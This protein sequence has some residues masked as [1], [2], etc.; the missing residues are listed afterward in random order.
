[1][2][3]IR[4]FVILLVLGSLCLIAGLFSQS[5]SV[6]QEAVRPQKPLQYEAR[7]TIKLIQVIVVDKQGKPVTNLRKEDFVLTDNGQEMKLT[8]YERHMLSL[9]SAEAPV[10]ERVVSTPLQ[11][12]RLLNRK[13]FLFFD[14]AYNNPAGVR[15]MGETARRFLDTQVLPTDEIGVVSY[16]L[17]NRLK[18]HLYL[19]TDHQKVRNLVSKIGLRDSAER[20]EDL[21]DKYQRQLK[22]GGLADARP[23]A[24][25][26]LPMPDMPGLDMAEMWRLSTITYI[27]SLTALAYAL[28][29]VPG[30]K[31]LVLFSEGIP[32]PVLYCFP[33]AVSDLGRKYENF[34]KELGTSNVSVHALYTGGITLGDSQ[35]GAWTLAKTSYETGG[36]YWGNMYNYEPFIEKVQTSTGSYYVLGYPVSEAWDGKY[37]RIQVTVNRP[38]C[39]VRAQFGYFNP[40]PFADYTDLEKRIQLVDLA[41]ADKPLSQTPDRFEM[42]ALP[43]S[44]DP[45]GNLV[46]AARIPR[47]KL[48]K[49]A[50]KKVEVV[51]LVFNPADEIVELRRSEEDLTKL[52]PSGAY[53]LSVL[54]VPPGAYKCRIV[55]RNLETGAAAVAGVST[56]VPE[57]KASGIALLPPTLW[58]PERSAFYLKGFIPK[59]SGKAPARP[60]SEILGFDTRQYVPY[61]EKTLSSPTEI[62]A[63]FRCAVA[64]I[65]ASKIKISAFLENLEFGGIVAVPLTILSKKDELSGKAYLARLEIPEVEPGPYRLYLKAEEET[66]G[67]SSLIANDFKVERKNSNLTLLP[68]LNSAK[69]TAF[70]HGVIDQDIGFS[71]AR[72][73]ACQS[74]DTRMS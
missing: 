71:K 32:Y 11:A 34:L 39:E 69:S 13:F 14:F 42:A 40:K 47:E 21:E 67:E 62:W 20:F 30:Q 24:K 38:G 19:T 70:S 48:D 37:H 45:A 6:P 66:S 33:V 58:K 44:A 23:E 59:V 27:E 18:F 28:R 68:D 64:K 51:N 49:V 52:S 41:L 31:H 46:F 53:L 73:K 61:T 56:A 63:S 16:S 9:P 1:M 72:S 4:N 50:G 3:R 60:L 74:T 7:V 29:S 22:A 2:M 17:L 15:K 8:E 35:T 25:L 55:M 26:T 12:P 54:A 36:Q 65:A 57:A 10:E 43:F 5:S